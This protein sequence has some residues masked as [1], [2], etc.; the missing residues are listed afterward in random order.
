MLKTLVLSCL[1]LLAAGV[2]LAEDSEAASV[3]IDVSDTEALKSNLD[4]QVTISGQCTSAAW[5]ASG[6]V[7]V[8]RFAGTK[9]SRFTAVVFVRDRD[10]IDAAFDGN[11]ADAFS[12]QTLR[13]KGK[14]QEYDGKNEN[15]KGVPEIVIRDANQV[16]IMPAEERPTTAP[17]DA[18]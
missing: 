12:K 3:V 17:A 10:K 15:L 4:K 7:M 18:D 9:E 2:A 16:T 13:I 1:V 8:I 14:L 11:A 5:S 6:K